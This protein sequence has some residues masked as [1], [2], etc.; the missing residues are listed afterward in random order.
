MFLIPLLVM[1]QPAKPTEIQKIEAIIHDLGNLKDAEFI[2]NGASYT[3]AEA[4]AHLRRK[5][6][7]A[8][9]A[10]K[11]APDFI[12][13]CGTD[14]SMS[15]KPYLIRFKDGHEIKASDLLWTALKKLESGN[16]KS[17]KP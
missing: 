17:P 13:L 12:R 11:S 2:R 15:G 14:S 16:E 7:N 1:E 10:V 8:G 9:N 3:A 5:W 6:K 4:A